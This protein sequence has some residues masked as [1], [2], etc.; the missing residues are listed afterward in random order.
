MRQDAMSR[1][2]AMAR[3]GRLTS[4][5]G[6]NSRSKRGM[7]TFSVVVSDPLGQHLPKMRL[8]QRDH[9]IEALAPGRADEAFAVCIGLR[10]THR[11]PQH[12]QRHRIQGVVDGL[13]EDGV[14]IVYEVIVAR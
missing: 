4:G 3:L 7:R 2:Q 8:V 1:R 13:R 11:R 6:W 12:L 9:P 14:A 5:L 10:S